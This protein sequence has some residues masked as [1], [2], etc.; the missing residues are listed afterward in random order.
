M[1]SRWRCVSSEGFCTLWRGEGWLERWKERVIV[2]VVKKGEGGGVQRGNFDGD[3]IQG[4]YADSGERLEEV[5]EEKDLFP[6]N[7][8]RYRKGMGALDNVYVVNYLMNR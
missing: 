8:I 2:P 7:H 3:V 1:K 6:P 5:V 4:V